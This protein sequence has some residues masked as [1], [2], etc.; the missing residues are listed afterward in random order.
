[1]RTI[2][3]FEMNA[4]LKLIE[5]MKV[6]DEELQKIDFYTD[7]STKVAISRDGIVY[8]YVVPVEDWFEY[9]PKEILDD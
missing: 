9:Q 3:D 6:I 7:S 8:G 1:M 5:A 4:A 2:T